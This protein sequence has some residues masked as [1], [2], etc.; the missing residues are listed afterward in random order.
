MLPTI[1]G[2]IAALIAAILL[3]AATR[4]DSF[5]VERSTTIKAPPERVFGYINDFHNWPAWSPWERMDPALK[6]TY[7]GPTSG[8]GSA[9]AW[10]GNSKVGSGRME[11]QESSPP[12]KI[13]INLDFMKPMEAHNITEFTL[14]PK[15]DTTDV[16]WAMYGPSP[17]LSKVM[18]T[19]FS[20]EKMVGGSFAEGLAN[21]KA[22]AEANK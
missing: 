15:G 4:P 18:Q 1:L 16:T 12:G 9:Y 20:M 6:R 21:L 8:K 2:V 10:E 14:V 7:S 22:A 19:F 13:L 3:F 5:R 17:Y 11:I